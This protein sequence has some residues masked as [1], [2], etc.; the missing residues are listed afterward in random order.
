MRHSPAYARAPLAALALAAL[1]LAGAAARAGV[2]LAETERGARGESAPAAEVIDGDTLVLAGGAEVRLVGIQAPKL[3]L[4][5]A[6]FP[7]WP[8]AE[9]ARRALQELSLGRRLTLYYG[10]QRTDRH[11]R[12]LAHLFDE[13]GTWLQGEMLARGLARVYSFADNR[14]LVAGMLALEEGARAARRGL[15]ADPFYRVLTPEE[16]GRAIG[17]FQIV[18]GRVVAVARASGRTYLNFG[19]DWRS[20]FTVSIPPSALRL[21]R[22]AGVAPEGYQGRRLRVRGWLGL[23]N[24]PMIE[25][26]HPEQ[27]ER[28]QD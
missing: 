11:G 27:I 6:N 25:A 19:A 26:T 5:R 17:T 23:R 15:W 20:D 16:T 14:A 3:P 24:G 2:T 10:G 4:G 12:L 21:F 8:L 22:A 13:A 18:E 9:E 28:L 7:T 1:L